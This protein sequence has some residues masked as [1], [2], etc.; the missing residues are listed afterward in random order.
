MLIHAG[1]VLS[2]L[3]A[4]RSRR[5]VRWER[6]TMASFPALQEPRA[7]PQPPSAAMVLLLMSESAATSLDHDAT[8]VALHGRSIRTRDVPVSRSA[9]DAEVQRVLGI[10]RRLW[11][12]APPGGLRLGLHAGRAEAGIA[13]A[14]A[15]QAPETIQAV[16]VMGCEADHLTQVHAYSPP[17]LF[18]LEPRDMAHLE[19]CRQIC[20]RA[21]AVGPPGPFTAAAKA[22]WGGPA[23][24][25]ETQPSSRHRVVV[26]PPDHNTLCATECGARTAEQ[27]AQWFVDCL[28]LEEEAPAQRASVL[29]R[30]VTG[31][32]AER[33][34]ATR[35]RRGRP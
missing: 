35:D 8:T 32:H 6:S 1:G 4:T 30:P 9:S 25:W 17:C 31:Q 14:V 5:R 2:T 28:G 7:V 3:G 16:V 13:L 21:Q 33:R 12:N 26:L 34:S 20:E 29:P 22:T 27:A 24:P 18:V 11:C 19:A 10:V 15:A 23:C